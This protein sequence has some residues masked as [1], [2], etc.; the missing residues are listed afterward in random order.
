MLIFHINIFASYS[1]TGRALGHK[2]ANLKDCDGL[3]PCVV[4]TNIIRI[5]QCLTEHFYQNKSASKAYD[6]MCF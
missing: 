1:D 2:G 6:Y 3:G 5:F 4:K